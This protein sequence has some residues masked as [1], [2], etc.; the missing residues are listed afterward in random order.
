MKKIMKIKQLINVKTKMETLTFHGHSLSRVAF[1]RSLS[2]C[3]V[4]IVGNLSLNSQVSFDSV[5]SRKSYGYFVSFSTEFPSN[6]VFIEL[7]M[8]PISEFQSK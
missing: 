2:H 5:V 4:S 1:A 6:C 7:F 8:K 3:V